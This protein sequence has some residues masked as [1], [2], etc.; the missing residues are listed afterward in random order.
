M[1]AVFTKKDE[2]LLSS[3][4]GPKPKEIEDKLSSGDIR[5]ITRGIYTENLVDPVEMITRRNIWSI[6]AHKVPEAIV[7]FRTRILGKPET[8]GTVFLSYK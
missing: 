7:D 1:I 4:K 8:D 6:I 3:V 5:Q 2:L